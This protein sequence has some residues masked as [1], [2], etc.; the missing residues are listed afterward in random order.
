MKWWT[1]SRN[2]V[3]PQDY[4]VFYC[5][6]P[7][8]HSLIVVPGWSLLGPLSGLWMGNECAGQSK[9][10]DGHCLWTPIRSH[11]PLLKYSD[12]PNSLRQLMFFGSTDVQHAWAIQIKWVEE[13]TLTWLFVAWSK[14]IAFAY[15]RCPKA[16]RE[17]GKGEQRWADNPGKSYGVVFWEKLEVQSC[18]H[19][20]GR[21]ELS[22]I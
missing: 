7:I 15:L 13:L 10:P 4:G 12:S 21:K 22:H 6:R 2:W 16:S 3:Q 1:A 11:T 14:R 8:S 17:W 18:N 9:N 19:C 5:Q 20:A